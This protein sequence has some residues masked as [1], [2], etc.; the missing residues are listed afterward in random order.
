MKEKYKT[1]VVE[2]S[3]YARCQPNDAKSQLKEVFNT[4]KQEILKAKL[5]ELESAHRN[6]KHCKSWQ[7]INDISNRK[8]RTRGRVE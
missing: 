7:M 8:K 2:S 4:V 3:E 5:Q 6:A 1:Y